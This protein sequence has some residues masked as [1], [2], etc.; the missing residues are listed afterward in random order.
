M[1]Q[2]RQ[3]YE[4]E[5][6]VSPKHLKLEHN[7]DLVPYLQFTKEDT[8]RRSDKDG[9]GFFKPNI[10]VENGIVSGKFT[11]LPVRSTK[12]DD[13]TLPGRLSTSSWTSSTISEEYAMSEAVPPLTSNYLLE[14]SPQKQVSV[15]E[16]N[17]FNGDEIKF[18]GSFVI[19][20]PENQTIHDNE[21][22]GRGRTE[23]YC[24]NPGFT[25]CVKQHIKVSREILNARIG[26][27]AFVDL[28][29]DDMEEVVAEKWTED[30]ELLFHEV[31]YSNPVSSSGRNFWNHLAAEFSSRSNH[32]IVSYY[33]NVFMLRRR[34]ELIQ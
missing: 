20:M 19:P 10:G 14:R 12:G 13:C 4:E 16:W 26:L 6:D 15:P 23:C 9:G 18:L 8:P 3:L 1:V 2:K 30:D 33:F 25:V 21:T 31:V 24:Q 29:F 28:G 11:D 22:V 5:Y 32:E 7:C 34:T 27:K 17:E